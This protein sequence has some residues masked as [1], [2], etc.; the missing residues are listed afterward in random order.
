MKILVTSIPTSPKECLFAKFPTLNK[1]GIM[2]KCTFNMNK[3]INE[4]NYDAWSYSKDDRYV[5]A[6]CKGKDCPYLTE[7][8]LYEIYKLTEYNNERNY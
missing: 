5:C 3:S 4:Y 1:D 6:L 8:S 7:A 2:P